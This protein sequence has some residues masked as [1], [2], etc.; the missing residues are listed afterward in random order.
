M[1]RASLASTAVLA[2]ACGRVGFS[3]TPDAA[4][5]GEEQCTLGPW[6]NTERLAMLASIGDDWEPAMSIDGL[7][8]VFASNR[9]DVVNHLYVATRASTSE[10]FDNVRALTELTGGTMREDSPAWSLDGSRLYFSRGSRAMSAEHLGGGMF[11]APID[12]ALPDGDSWVMANGELETFYMVYPAPN[13]GDLKHATRGSLADPWTVDGALDAMNRV[14]SPDGWPAFD[15]A[16]QELYV[17]QESA[18]GA[19]LRVASRA[20]PGE[21]FGPLSTIEFGGD[22]DISR[23]GRT[24][25]FA[26]DRLGGAGGAD[27]YMLTRDCE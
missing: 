20:S 6:G 24:L 27:I 5:A 26:A 8:L 9:D 14:G 17:E 10:S 23:D 25:L 11:A 15:E 21:P 22:P 19:E 12:A 16:R 13:D 2:A 1:L 18:S 4:T 3:P 7:V